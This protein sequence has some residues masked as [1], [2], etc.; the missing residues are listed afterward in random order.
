MGGLQTYITNSNASMLNYAQAYTAS[1]LTT[2]VGSTAIFTAMAPAD[3]NAAVAANAATSD[4]KVYIRQC[5]TDLWMQN[6]QQSEVWVRATY[7][8]VRKNIPINEWATIGALLQEQAIG[9]DNWATPVTLG[10]T[11]ALY[12]KYG[13]TKLFTLR[14]GQLKHMKINCKYKNSVLVTQNDISDTYFTATKWTCGLIVKLIPAPRVF[15]NTGTSSY[16]GIAPAPW[17][18]SMMETSTVSLYALGNDNPSVTYNAIPV[19]TGT[20]GYFAVD[21]GSI[22]TSTQLT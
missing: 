2:T 8:R 6:E 11:A 3:I 10:P 12:L 22:K 21:S 18:I 5:K 4:S 16:T 1:N 14:G 17:G 9:L 13:R 20:A 15:V 19:P 7:F